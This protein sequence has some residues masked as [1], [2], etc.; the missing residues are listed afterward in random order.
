MGRS[1][2]RSGV[3]LVADDYST[4]IN[5]IRTAQRTL[6]A[7]QNTARRS[8]N[9]T[10]DASNAQRSLR[11]LEAELRSSGQRSAQAFNTGFQNLGPSLQRSASAGGRGAGD[12]FIRGA[13]GVFGGGALSAVTSGF[14]LGLGNI[15]AQAFVGAFRAGIEGLGEVIGDAIRLEQGVIDIAALTGVDVND[16]EA[17]A[18]VSNEI[19]DAIE[20]VATSPDLA[21][22]ADTAA[23]VAQALIKTGQDVQTVTD[24]LLDDTIRLQN[25]VG[26]TGTIEEYG[27]VAD[28]VGRSLALFG[29]GAEQSGEIVDA[30][31]GVITG[32]S[33]RNITDYNFALV[34]SA[35]AIRTLDLELEEFNATIVA[36]SASFSGG[37]TQATALSSALTRLANPT[38]DSAAALR[39][40]GI[41]AFDAQGNFVGLERLSEQLAAS[42]E[43]GFSQEELLNLL[44]RGFGAVGAE[45]AVALGNV[46]DFGS[47]IEQ[48]TTGTSAFDIAATRTQTLGARL[49]NLV[50]QIEFLG[51]G[52][53]SPFV[54]ELNPAVEAAQNLVGALTD[55]AR[56][57]GEAFANFAAPAIQGVA[58]ALNALAL[59]GGSTDLDALSGVIDAQINA[60]QG[61]FAALDNFNLAGN[62]AADLF[63]GGNTYEQEQQRIVAGFQELQRLIDVA[64]SEAA[65]GVIGIDAYIDRIAQIGAASIRSGDVTAESLAEIRQLYS[66]IADE[67]GGLEAAVAE[68]TP[69]LEDQQAQLTATLDQIRQAGLSELEARAINL[70]PEIGIEAATE[71]FNQLREQFNT[72]FDQLEASL[73]ERQIFAG[74][75]VRIEANAL[76]NRITEQFQSEVVEPIQQDLGAQLS[77]A[78]IALGLDAAFGRFTGLD[79]DVQGILSGV[80]DGLLS[81]SDA[82]AENQALTDAQIIQYQELLAITELL[83]LDSFGLASAFDL[84]TNSEM[85]Q[86]QGTDVLLQGLLNVSGQYQAGQISAGEYASAI[87]V[88]VE[89]LFAAAQAAGLSDAAIASAFGNLQTLVATA[90]QAA[91]A[92]GTDTPGASAAGNQRAQAVAFRAEQQAQQRQ[93][94]IR[95]RQQREQ[96]R[97]EREAAQSQRAAQRAQQQAARQAEQAAREIESTLSNVEGLFSRSRVTQD[98]LDAA[99]TGDYIEQADEFVRQ[100]EDYVVNGN[101]EF[102]GNLDQARAALEA[103][104]LQASSDPQVLFR[105]FVTA[106]ENQTLFFAEEN[107]ALINQGAIEGAVELKRKSEIGRQN[108]INA[109]GGLVDASVEGIISGIGAAATDAIA[110]IDA[111]DI[112]VPE[113]ELPT[114]E[115]LEAQITGLDFSSLEAI[116]AEALTTAIANAFGGLDLS[117]LLSLGDVEAGTGTTRALD[118]TNFFAFELPVPKI[119]LDVSDY[120]TIA[121]PETPTEIDLS[122]L[123]TF[124]GA[125]GA[126]RIDLS[127][128][129]NFTGVAG[130]EQ[131][132][133][134]GLVSFIGELDTEEIDRAALVDF[135]NELPEAI[136]VDRDGL[137]TFVGML[138]EAV[139]IDQ[140]ALVDIVGDLPA[141]VTVDQSALVDI[142]GELPASFT[143]DRSGLVSFIGEFP[144]G[145]TVD[146]STL[147]TLTGILPDGI[148]IDQSALVEFVGLL[149]EAVE[150]DQSTLVEFINELP[151]GETVDRATLV[152]F[153]GLLPDGLEIDRSTLIDYIGLLPKAIEV[154]QAGLVQFIGALP[155]AVEVDRAGLVDVIGL[156]PDAVEIDRSTLVEIV[157]LLPEGLEI[158]QSTL[159]EFIGLLPDGLEIDRSAF[160][161]IF[162]ELPE[163]IVID[164][165]ELVTFTG[166]PAAIQDLFPTGA[167]NGTRSI[168]D[169]GGNV[170]VEPGSRPLPVEVISDTT[171]GIQAIDDFEA[172]PLLVDA[173][174]RNTDALNAVGPVQGPEEDP[175]TEGPLTEFEGAV[176]TWLDTVDLWD[177]AVASF[178]AGLQAEQQSQQADGLTATEIQANATATTNQTSA[179]TASTTA[180]REETRTRSDAIDQLIRELDDLTDSL[181][182]F[183]NITSDLADE[184]VAFGGGI[185]DTLSKLTDLNSS[186]QTLIDDLD[187]ASLG[188]ALNDLTN[189]IRDAINDVRRAAEGD[190][191]GG[192]GSQPDPNAGASQLGGLVSGRTL[193]GEGGREL[194]FNP[195]QGVAGLVGSVGPQIVN[196]DPGT[197]VIPNAETERII[198]RSGD[199]NPTLGA[200][201]FGGFFPTPLPGSPGRIGRDDGPGRR[202]NAV[203]ATENRFLDDL[204]R[205]FDAVNQTAG[206]LQAAGILPEQTTGGNMFD[207]P[208]G[209]IASQ[210]ASAVVGSRQQGASTVVNIYN[211]QS[212]DNSQVVNNNY[213][214]TTNSMRSQERVDS[215]FRI[216]ANR[217]R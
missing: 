10:I 140:S 58:D 108:V 164:R 197:V 65:S 163:P 45:A 75:E 50:D 110:G 3:R 107:T 130:S 4:F 119:L 112:D 198:S 18:Q 48:V 73:A 7:F 77:D 155:E 14:F 72:E 63:T 169:V 25:A 165:S 214:L 62:F 90:Q 216:L 51:I 96:A 20:R 151:T 124:A 153:V 180:I 120:W 38:E 189:A 95:Q 173:L 80:S 21:V 193:V 28:S 79:T 101:E 47:A 32:S 205:Q 89:Q 26:E 99:L 42:F 160:V 207:R 57:L 24:G 157:G 206:I 204:L 139:E 41:Q 166:D 170:T 156:L 31:A 40:L 135:I 52:L 44:S 9:P 202:E 11:Q 97:A 185:N 105:Q 46:E 74:P 132:D 129:V 187:S 148:E 88:L 64:N 13:S 162:G 199:A 93:A 116:V 150:V 30:I 17:I 94:R 191:G 161:N 27:R 182:D 16:A 167:I 168:G 149:P 68:S 128:A 6:E 33:T 131:V 186:F 67:V 34:N 194:W 55:D 49:S 56:N 134:S 177:D 78:D 60:I 137:V 159:V 117:G 179:T 2:P 82:F 136:E 84:V 123:V 127:R 87:G 71:E 109:F 196:F 35:G 102:A 211:Q 113:V 154:D 81:V 92:T 126:A 171:G 192:N 138:P 125:A 86:A 69:T 22:G 210:L 178:R 1:L 133:L 144:E 203:I 114:Q 215:D 104:G 212:Y 152:E 111:G 15:G 98:D 43:R 37:R 59:A 106:W 5:R 208:T 54:D 91:A 85:L 121:T 175:T 118:I 29:L 184:F 19:A 103:A 217:A 183:A 176:A 122:S 83:E 172:A 53:A 195:Q 146:R 76:R 181:G 174:D 143:V 36:T 213:A 200:M 61:R 39:T 70:E 8:V 23:Q 209:N 115:E 190:G 12:A 145:E 158:D 147:V 66:V 100:L 201:Q 142:V 188:D 141:S